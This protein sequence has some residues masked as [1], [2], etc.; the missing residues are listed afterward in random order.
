MLY[1]RQ[2]QAGSFK[3]EFFVGKYSHRTRVRRARLSR[4]YVVCGGGGGGDCGAQCRPQV[5]CETGFLCVGFL[6]WRPQ[7]RG[8]GE[9][10][11]GR[12]MTYGGAGS[13]HATNISVR[14]RACMSLP[15]T[16]ECGVWTS[17]HFLFLIKLIAVMAVS[18]K[19]CQLC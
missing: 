5:S 8:R 14:T 16:V 1:C 9:T 6:A 15:G 19:T 13:L 17:Q 12:D 10:V 11:Q 7:G 4:Y 2:G 18:W 3:T